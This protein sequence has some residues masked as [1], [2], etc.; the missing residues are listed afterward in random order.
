MGE[1]VGGEVLTSSSPAG[2]AVG[3][4][5]VLSAVSESKSASANAN[6]QGQLDSMAENAETAAKQSARSWKSW[7]FGR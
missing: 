7:F 2:D 4:S 1:G 6:Q 5:P 3:N